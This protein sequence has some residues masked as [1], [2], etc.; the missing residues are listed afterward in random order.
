MDPLPPQVQVVY[1]PQTPRTSGLAITSLV[2]G[3]LSV[4]GAAILF[5]PPVFAV[6]LGHVSLGQCKRDPGLGGR[7]MAIAGLVMGYL[8]LAMW[9]LWLL[10][11]G[12]LIALGIAG[13]A[14]AQ[15]HA[16]AATY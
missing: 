2:L 7:G 6:I 16:H 1:T 12:G 14:A 3:I 10:F 4:M 9:L 15:G 11:F 5:L 13:A 8:T